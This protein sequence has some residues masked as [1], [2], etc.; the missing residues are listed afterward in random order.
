MR[1]YVLENHKTRQYCLV[2]SPDFSGDWH[3][4]YFPGTED[5][6]DVEAYRI[7]GTDPSGKVM[8]NEELA[9]SR[10]IAVVFFV[11]PGTTNKE[12]VA[13]KAW[14]RS[15]R[16]V[17][18]SETKKIKQWCPIEPPPCYMRNNV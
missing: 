14:L 2:D 9:N 10:G 12:A 6:L 4:H 16:D 7:D 3:K 1:R 17:V 18:H 5:C 11:P 13:A 15:Q 8:Y